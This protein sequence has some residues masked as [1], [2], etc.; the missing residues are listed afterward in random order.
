MSAKLTWEE[1]KERFNEKRFKKL[2]LIDAECESYGGSHSV[3]EV[4]CLEHGKFKVE[5]RKLLTAMFG[6][7]ECAKEYRNS[8]HRKTTEEFIAESKEKF[9]GDTFGYT[10]VDYVNSKTKVELVCKQHGSFMIRPSDHLN[11][12]EGCPMCKQS[13]LE[14]MIALEL[15][16]RKMFYIVQKRFDWLGKMSLDFYIPSIN[17]GIECQGKQHFLLGGWSKEFDFGIQIER[18]KKKKALCDDNGVKLVYFTDVRDIDFKKFDGVYSSENTFI[19]AS[20][21]LNRMIEY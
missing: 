2:R 6:C 16:N 17:V 20:E 5:S 15:R 10:N 3:I 11:K 4:E 18:D 1:F 14:N 7:N 9:G 8:I 21:M 12:F 19:S 13:K